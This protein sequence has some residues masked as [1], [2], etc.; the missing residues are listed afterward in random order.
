MI[1][2]ALCVVASAFTSCMDDTAEPPVSKD[3]GVTSQVS[4]GAANM[5]IA[6][7]KTKHSG[8]M[9]STNRYEEVT[10]DEIIE[11]IVVANDVS[12]NLYQYLFIRDVSDAA[13]DQ[14][15]GI[16]IRNSH[17]SPFF[18]LGQGVRINLKGLY[19]GNYSGVPKIGQPYLTSKGNYRLGPMLF[20]LLRTN[21]ELFDVSE[22][23]KKK[24]LTPIKVDEAWMSAHADYASIP[25]LVTVE[26][27]LDEADGDAIFAPDELKD[28]GYCV[29]RSMTMNSQKIIVRTATQI[30]IAHTIMPTEKVR[31]TGVLSY[32]PKGSG[33][34][35]WQINLRDLKDLEVLPE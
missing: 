34:P 32:Y 21:V 35:E 24:A 1:H 17:V 22:A 3:N 28:E 2:I 30:D 12:G 16:G 27:T 23:T 14:C 4:L 11:G 15:I 9:S 25:A 10:T 8:V 13:N 19:I 31:L 20:N 7:L 26:G 29:N 6:Q 33:S 18:P 5:T